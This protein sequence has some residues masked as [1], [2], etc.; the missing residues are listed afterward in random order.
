MLPRC[1]P[2]RIG[3]FERDDAKC[4]MAKPSDS[5]VDL[6]FE[7]TLY[8]A[9]LRAPVRLNRRN[10]GQR[11][12]ALI[13]LGWMVGEASCGKVRAF[14]SSRARQLSCA[15]GVPGLGYYPTLISCGR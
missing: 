15:E 8:P 12:R 3:S 11:Q 14:E 10:A 2:E 4:L 1:Y 5:N 6:A 7:A 9:E 13:L